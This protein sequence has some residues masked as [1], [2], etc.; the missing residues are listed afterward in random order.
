MQK[1]KAT[2]DSDSDGD[3]AREDSDALRRG[4]EPDGDGAEAKT[5]SDSAQS[6][7]SSSPDTEEQAAGDEAEAS[8]RK[9]PDDQSE[10]SAGEQAGDEPETSAAEDTDDQPETSAGEQESGDQPEASAGKD[11]GDEPEASAGKDAG[12]QPEAS[13]GKDAGDQSETSAGQESG[14]QPQSSAETDAGGKTEAEAK[15][16]AHPE[17][18]A[19]T[20]SDEPAKKEAEADAKNA[21]P[22]PPRRDRPR[23]PWFGLFNFL[24]I[25]GLAGAGGYYWYLQDRA[26][27]QAVRDYEA[28]IADLRAQINA[29]PTNAQLI[30]E[31]EPVRRVLGQ[32]TQQIT[33]L[34]TGQESLSQ[35]S[36]KLYE[37][38]GRNKNEWQLAEVEYL[39]RVAQ[40]KLILQDDFAGAAITLQAASDLLGETGDPGMLPVRVR[41]SDEIADLRTRKRADLVGM[42]LTLA[43]LSREVL[44]LQPGFAPRIDEIPAEE[45]PAPEPPPPV[46]GDQ[47]WLERIS[48]YV[49]S[50]VVVR[51]ESLP[52]TA[53]EADIVDVGQ[54]L[55]DN[56]KLARWA[57]LE[58]D[59]YHYEMLLE[60]SVK[61]FREYYDLDNAANADF[62]G[63]LTD[64][65]KRVLK[66]EKPDI[67]GS[68]REMQRI[69]QRRELEP[70]EAT[71]A[72]NG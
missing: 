8:A 37:L 64:L 68:L 56:L 41:I 63:Q 26:A 22:P 38:Y 25:L 15:D 60:R 58:R 50:L 2:P 36:E 69:L 72:T 71:E 55:S 49:D 12:D 54:A 23:R 3:G 67:T 53:I 57:V 20:E 30:D 19:E 7:Q 46:E 33:A 10:T 66:P 21:L 29:K 5:G 24:L 18:E 1:E 16:A 45:A 59:V 4:T 17:R 32:F 34:E 70:A 6:D 14:D 65:Q 13:A 47:N 11:A 39:M 48:S 31:M 51:R 42:T 44:M 40:H 61:L 62:L 28:A 9:D 52:P 35:A 43:Q 27:K